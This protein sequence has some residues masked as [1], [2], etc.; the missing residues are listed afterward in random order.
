MAGAG[1][2]RCGGL[3]IVTGVLLMRGVLAADQGT[4]T[5]REIATAIQEGAVP[6]SARQFRTIADHRRPLAVLI[7][8]TATK[9]TH[10]VNHVVFTGGTTVVL[11]QTVTALT[12]AQAGIYRVL[13]FLAG[14]SC[15]GLTGFIGMSLAVRGN[16]RTA[17][18]ARD[19]QDARRPQGRLPHR[20]HHRHAS[21]SASGCSGRR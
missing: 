16:V 8:F 12:F 7:F 19:G 4:A 21:A 14:A 20:R 5:M 13:C 1:P 9:V 6:F 11:H 3:G 18:A 15:S 2:R 10:T 17:A